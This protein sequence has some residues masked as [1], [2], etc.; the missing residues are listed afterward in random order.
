MLAL[1]QRAQHRDCQLTCIF[2]RSGADLQF[3][4]AADDAPGVENH[5][6]NGLR[7]DR[8]IDLMLGVYTA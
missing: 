4:M 7:N 5:I 2:P 6:L 8:G 1:A 3:K